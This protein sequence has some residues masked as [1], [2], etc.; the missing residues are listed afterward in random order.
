[1]YPGTECLHGLMTLSGDGMNSQRLPEL[2]KKLLWAAMTGAGDKYRI[3]IVGLPKD[4]KAEWVNIYSNPKELEF[5]T[6]I[7]LYS[8]IFYSLSGTNPNLSGMPTLRDAV[9]PAGI[10]EPAQDGIWKQSQD[11]GLNT[12]LIHMQDVLNQTNSEG[13][14]I[15]KEVTKLPIHA[16]VQR[17]SFR[18]FKIKI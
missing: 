18:R 14:N 8:T 6:G 3:P 13:I 12:F 15:W 2:V 10:T 11:P 17:I 7:S 1:M 4:G 16:R 5:Y 9:K